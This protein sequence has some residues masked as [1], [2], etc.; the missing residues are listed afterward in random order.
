MKLLPKSIISAAFISTA[1]LLSA[2]NEADTT[3]AAT[4]VAAVEVAAE[5]PAIQPQETQT[6]DE[7]PFMS[8]RIIAVTISEVTAIDHETRVVTL[9]GEDGESITLTVG[10]DARNLDQVNVGDIV[11]AEYIKDL[12]I[13]VMAVDNAQAVET[14]MTAEIR[15]DVGEMPAAATITTQVEVSI[16]E[17]INIEA[18]TFKLKDASGA[19]TEY[20]ARDPENLKKAAV[21]DVVVATLSEAM[22]ISVTKQEAADK[23]AAAE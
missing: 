18:N 23:P 21:G 15:S 14:E 5:A 6:A 8:S 3:S 4:P 16:V 9:K 19:I 20:V 1:V 10:E 2:C 22:A 17:E 11:T 12:T 7:K 13:E